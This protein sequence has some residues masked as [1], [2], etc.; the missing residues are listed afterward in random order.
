MLLTVTDW[1]SPVALGDVGA[2]D[3]RAE[4]DTDT[5]EHQGPDE[6]CAVHCCPLSVGDAEGPHQESR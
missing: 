2:E 3:G 1:A 4:N 5:D 6:R